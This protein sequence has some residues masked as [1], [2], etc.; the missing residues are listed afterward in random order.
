MSVIDSL[1]E[2]GIEATIML[3]VA[4][5]F[6]LLRLFLFVLSFLG[7]G[8]AFNLILSGISATFFGGWRMTRG[9]V[10]AGVKK[11]ASKVAPSAAKPGG[12]SSV[13]ANVGKKIAKAG[14]KKGISGVT[15]V[16]TLA[17]EFLPFIGD[18]IP[19]ELIQ[20][21]GTIVTG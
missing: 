10:K 13:A 17:G 3:P 7:I 21:L 1:A 14:I 18:I 12:G 16:L 5:M 19:W 15:F 20:T 2:M 8:I 6:Y 9:F 4:A 11:A